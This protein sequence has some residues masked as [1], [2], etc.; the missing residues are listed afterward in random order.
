MKCPHCGQEHS[1]D[2]KFCPETG[3][4]LELQFLYCDK[5]N[6]DFRQPLPLSAKFCPN[7][8]KP[9]DV[10]RN[11]NKTEDINSSG[12]STG[13]W[14]IIAYERADNE[15]GYDDQK[16]ITVFKDNSQNIIYSGFVQKDGWTYGQ[17]VRVW[18]KSVIQFHSGFDYNSYIEVSPD[19]V[20]KNMNVNSILKG[21][22]LGHKEC[23]GFDVKTKTDRYVF[24]SSKTGRFYDDIYGNFIINS[25]EKGDFTYF[26][27]FDRYSEKLLHKNILI[28]Y[29]GVAYEKYKE[30]E[31]WLPFYDEDTLLLVN[32]FTQFRLEENEVVVDN[33]M[34]D[35]SWQHG[36][37]IW[38]YSTEK[39][40][41]TTF[42]YDD[43]EPNFE[44]ISMIRMRDENGVIIKEIDAS[45]LFLKNNFK[46]NRCL[47]V[48][49]KKSKKIIV[50]LDEF[51]N[52]NE[53]PNS[54][55]NGDPEDIDCFFV[56]KDVIVVNDT[57]GAIMMTIN[58]KE[59]FECYRMREMA[60]GYV[61]FYDID[62]GKSGVIDSNG[63]II[64]P[65][66]YEEFDILIK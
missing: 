55:V 1:D 29:G 8:G 11:Q 4:K 46:F 18:D 23:N 5:P 20:K 43:Y 2:T 25:S 39:R 35:P 38:Y 24:K 52:V 64:I 22:Y 27:I 36:Y 14:V 42:R 51:G 17:T 49:T 28:K 40:L 12:E 63:D 48:K 15:D 9:L 57:D 66:K 31:F 10:Q 65:A 56:T 45:G 34:Y 7:C 30:Y 58:G 33:V 61:E 21:N 13:H 16:Y 37:G 62:A 19:G 59:I 47:A 50:Y 41:L 26:D 3:K 54:K 60:G 53:I 44:G 6:C 32:K